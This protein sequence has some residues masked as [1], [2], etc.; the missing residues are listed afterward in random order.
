MTEEYKSN[1]LDLIRGQTFPYPLLSTEIYIDKTIQSWD[2]YSEIPEADASSIKING[3]VKGSNNY[4]LYGEYNNS[5]PGIDYTTCGFII[6][7]DN[8]FNILQTLTKYDSGTYFRAFSNLKEAEDNTYYGIDNYGSYTARFIMLNNF[9]IPNSVGN[10]VVK[11]RYSANFTDND[12]Y[13]SGAKIFKNP[14]SSHY[15]FVGMSEGSLTFKAI[16]LTVNVGAANTWNSYTSSY[17][18]MGNAYV[19]FDSQDR[20]F[21]ETLTNNG[22]YIKRVY[23]NYA[24]NTFTSTNVVASVDDEYIN[25]VAYMSSTQYYY[26]YNGVAKAV[27][28]GTI[29]LDNPVPNNTEVML[30]NNDL[31]IIYSSG[32]TF[33][34]F[35]Y[36]GNIWQPIPITNAYIG[37]TFIF[38]EYNMLKIISVKDTGYTIITE[39]Y[40]TNN[41]NSET[42]DGRYNSTFPKK[43]RLFTNGKLSFARNAYNISCFGN[44][45]TT[46]VEIPNVYLNDGN[47]NPSQLISETNSVIVNYT[48]N[49]TKN[50]YENVYLNFINTI[51]AYDEDTGTIFDTTNLVKNVSGLGVS[52]PKMIYWN[53]TKDG[54]VVDSGNV[55]SIT[56]LGRL[57]VEYY[58]SFTPTSEADRLN[59]VNND[60][61][62]YGWIDISNCVPGTTYDIHQKIRLADIPLGDQKVIW[63]DNKVQYNGNDV[64][65]YT[66][67]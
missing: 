18:Y 65:Y 66:S 13:T 5:T 44:S 27:G 37:N 25:S 54:V 36:D 56:K 49:L 32:N 60:G 45:F 35:R 50:I 14:N 30:Y 53:T 61:Q 67:I 43:A 64:V 12:F 19:N 8:D 16:D 46:T 11:L 15:A 10:Y 6:I 29:A 41:Y 38:S 20:V 3:I 57:T 9:T 4:A 55:D 62:V 47:I 39:D 24:S 26:V 23:K 22:G 1:I 52:T 33:Y 31:Y 40:N 59:F 28:T 48:E 2:L 34:Y 51:N 21:I 7:L 42:I 58:I 17:D 63:N